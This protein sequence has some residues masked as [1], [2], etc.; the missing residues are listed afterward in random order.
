M[1]TVV[2]CT[3]SDALAGV[4]RMLEAAGITDV[5]RCDGTDPRSFC[6]DKGY[7]LIVSVL[8]F[9]GELGLNTIA[10]FCANTSAEQVAFVPSK[11]YDEVSSKLNG[12][13]V[14]LLPKNVP[15]SIAVNVIRKAVSVKQS[16]DMIRGENDGLRRR[17]EADRLIYRAKCMLIEYLNMT[18]EEA[19]RYLQK[20]AMDRHSPME[21]QAL[22]ILKTYQR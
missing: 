7:E 12:L 14:S 3:S 6:M 21:E 2:I 11:I 19:H 16:M 18:E 5:T 9:A 17:A 8:P 1:R 15:M 22:E 4:E 20:R 13:N 10:Y